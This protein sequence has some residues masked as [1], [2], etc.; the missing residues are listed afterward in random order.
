M[1]VDERAQLRKDLLEY[2]NR[3]PP[4]INSGSYGLAIQ[5]KEDVVRFRKLANKAT[6]T[7]AQLNSA[8]SRMNSYW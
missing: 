6:A 8:I 7:E 2:C 5:F 4:S 1:P 3:V